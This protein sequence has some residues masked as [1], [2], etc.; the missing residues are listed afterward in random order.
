MCNSIDEELFQLTTHPTSITYHKAIALSRDV[1][2]LEK[3]I[4]KLIFKLT[5]LTYHKAIA[6][7]RD[8]AILEK[9]IQKLIFK[10]TDGDHKCTR[11]SDHTGACICTCG[12]SR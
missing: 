2:I 12:T 8:V 1:A 4:Q 7:S 11:K 3:F 10:L 6:L 9:F 5:T